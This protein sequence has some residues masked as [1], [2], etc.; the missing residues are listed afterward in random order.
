MRDE[1]HVPPFW[2]GYVDFVIVRIN[3]KITLRNQIVI[4]IKT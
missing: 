1:Q 2:W 4:G 3:Q